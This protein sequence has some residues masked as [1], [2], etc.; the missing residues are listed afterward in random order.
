MA[1]RGGVCY[2]RVWVP[3]SKAG[4]EVKK[5][6]TERQLAL[7]DHWVEPRHRR[8]TWTPDWLTAFSV[9]GAVVTPKRGLTWADWLQIAT[10]IWS[11]SMG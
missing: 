11:F 7:V 9:L 10:R 3:V 4:A 2:T 8:M 6:R 5:R 1:V